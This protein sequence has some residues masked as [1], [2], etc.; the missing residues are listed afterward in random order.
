MMADTNVRFSSAASA[1]AD[2]LP[3]ENDDRSWPKRSLTSSAAD[4]STATKDTS[5]TEIRALRHL[6]PDLWALVLS[7]TPYLDN[8]RCIAVSRSFLHVV[9]P[10]VAE[11]A[12][13]SSSELKTRPAHRFKAVGKVT[14]GCLYRHRRIMH[15]G[16]RYG[17]Y[18]ELGSD[19]K[20]RLEVDRNTATSV[21]PF[22]SAFPSLKEVRLGWYS[23]EGNFAEYDGSSDIF[24]H[25]SEDLDKD[26][27]MLRGLHAAICGAYR[28]RAIP[29]DTKVSGIDIFCQNV[30]AVPGPE[31]PRYCPRCSDSI[32]C[33]PVEKVA[34]G[35]RLYHYPCVPQ[36][37]AVDMCLKRPRGSEHL[38]TPTYILH[39]HCS[40][41]VT[42]KCLVAALKERKLIPKVSRQQVI[43]YF[44]DNPV[45]DSSYSELI[46][47]RMVMNG[48]PVKRSDLP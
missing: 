25:L 5:T 1:E 3:A 37:A 45:K 38:S 15:G 48:I 24:D 28:S 44:A 32:E 41:F 13:M 7:F 31:P 10:R 11:I 18:D 4:R 43:D 40:T 30:A 2:G 20:S 42:H 22:L 19:R 23:S 17:Q 14:V 33:F 12:V 46:Y 36:D 6:T 29:S 39:V 16:H 27:I 34:R 9:A 47:R 35:I 21:V 8:L 26:I